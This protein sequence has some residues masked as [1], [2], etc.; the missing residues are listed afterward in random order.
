MTRDE[1]LQ[2]MIDGEKVTHL[3][4]TDEEF[5]YMKGQ[6][7]WSEDGYNFGTVHDEF[8]WGKQMSTFDDGW[9]IYREKDENIQS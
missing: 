6:D 4:F 2:A 1:A 3:Y 5:I 7:I 9:S 8:W